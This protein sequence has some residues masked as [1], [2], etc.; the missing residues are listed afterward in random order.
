MTPTYDPVTVS[1]VADGVEKEIKFTG[2]VLGFATS[3][4]SRHTHH[5]DYAPPGERCSA[6]R[7]FVVTLYE[8]DPDDASDARYLVFTRGATAVP[9]EQ[10]FD[11]LTWVESPLEIIEV[12]TVRQD[13]RPTL[14][15]PSARVI[16]QAADRDNDVRRAYLERMENGHG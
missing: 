12:L 7:W 10:P 2:R 1:Y 14:P 9:G 5:S 16:A 6:C 3:E 8:A 11:K 15:K 4:D 13:G